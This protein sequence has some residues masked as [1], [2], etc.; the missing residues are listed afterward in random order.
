MKEKVE[1]YKREE[2][3]KMKKDLKIMKIEKK[4]MCVSN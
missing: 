4:R 1:M 3:K 2:G